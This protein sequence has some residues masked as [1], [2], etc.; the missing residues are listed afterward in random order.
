[1][2]LSKS[3]DFEEEYTKK[4]F[5]KPPKCNDDEQKKCADSC[6]AYDPKFKRAICEY[7]LWPYWWRDE[8]I[9]SCWCSTPI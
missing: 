9:T 4:K 8:K 6:I 1:M 5:G 7:D 2:S 3:E